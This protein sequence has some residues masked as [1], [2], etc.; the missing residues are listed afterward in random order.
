CRCYD[1]CYLHFTINKGIPFSICNLIWRGILHSFILQPGD[2]GNKTYS[3]AVVNHNVD[4]SDDRY[5]NRSFNQSKWNIGKSINLSRL[6]FLTKFRHY[7]EERRK[8][9]C[10]WLLFLEQNDAVYRIIV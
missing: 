9:R 2:I 10:E 5:K 1:K 4:D 3:K 8:Y 6:F 7:G